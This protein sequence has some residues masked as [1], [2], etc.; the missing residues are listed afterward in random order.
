MLQTAALPNFWRNEKYTIQEAIL[1]N[2]TQ[3]ESQEFI[4]PFTIR[5]ISLHIHYT[6]YM[7]VY[8]FKWF[9]I[10]SNSVNNTMRGQSEVRIYP[11]LAN[12]AIF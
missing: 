4:T 11:L 10:L 5:N 9:H 12:A 6:T 8:N 2:P 7:L 1:S 3:P